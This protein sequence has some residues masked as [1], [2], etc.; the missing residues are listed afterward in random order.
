VDLTHVN[1]LAELLSE[2]GAWADVLA[3]VRRAGSE[4]AAG[5]GEAALPV[6]LTVS[7]KERAERTT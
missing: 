1:L 6:D 7:Q 3:L 2:A 4:W 5:G